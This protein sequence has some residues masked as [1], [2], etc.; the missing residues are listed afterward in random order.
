[1]FTVVEIDE[2]KSDMA[3]AIQSLKDHFI[4]QLKKA[5]GFVRGTWFGNDSTGHSVVLF[6]NEEQA[7]QA[8]QEVDSTPAEGVRVVSSDVYEL[9]AQA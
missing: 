6:D 7:A 2:T 4:P 8:T 5:P 9:H 1:M 3:S